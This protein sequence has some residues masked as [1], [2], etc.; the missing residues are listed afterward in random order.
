MITQ[1]FTSVSRKLL[2]EAR[3]WE[4]LHRKLLG[5][6]G[7]TS[8]TIRNNSVIWWGGG[9]RFHDMIIDNSLEKEVPKNLK[10][11]SIHTLWR[12]QGEGK[13]GYLGENFRICTP[14]KKLIK[15]V[16]TDFCLHIPFFKPWLRTAVT[17]SIISLCWSVSQ[18]I[19]FTIYFVLRTF[20]TEVGC[21][22][23]NEKTLVFYSYPWEWRKISF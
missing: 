11:S 18:K 2:Y 7:C 13:M 22:L 17:S 14:K 19:C 5:F 23:L 4:N 6:V 1:L 12:V 9:E 8:F 3:N 15:K 16:I 21:I 20:Y 10:I